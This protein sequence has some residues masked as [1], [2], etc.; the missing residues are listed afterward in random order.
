MGEVERM[1]CSVAKDAAAMQAMGVLMEVK[2][3]KLDMH[4][5][6]CCLATDPTVILA[7]LCYLS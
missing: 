2:A 7:V 3:L 1:H 5:N 4:G 6:L